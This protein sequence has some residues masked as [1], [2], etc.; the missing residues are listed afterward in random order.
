MSRSA[1]LMSLLLGAALWPAAALAQPRECRPCWP[2][3]FD[4]IEISGSANVRFTQGTSEQVS[5]DGDEEA[6]KAVELEVRNGVLYVRP[7]GSWK[8]WNSRRVQLDITARDLK[9]VMIS[10]A[11]DLV[12]ATGASNIIMLKWRRFMGFILTATAPSIAW[13]PRGWP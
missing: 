2:G 7:G 10:G 9:R 13:R 5:V 3:P 11:A 6:Q 8:F 4:S 12:A 1:T